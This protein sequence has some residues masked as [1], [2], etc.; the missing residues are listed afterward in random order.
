MAEMVYMGEMGEGLGKLELGPRWQPEPGE[1]LGAEKMPT[2]YRLEQ[3][4]GTKLIR[5]YFKGNREMQLD[6]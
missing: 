1:E 3:S 6:W 2:K 5:D 4:E